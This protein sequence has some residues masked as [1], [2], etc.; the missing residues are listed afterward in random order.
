MRLKGIV[1]V[2]L[3]AFV[4]ASLVYLLV[5]E[6]RK[7]SAPGAAPE[8]A[9]GAPP[10]EAVM[11][12]PPAASE[13]PGPADGTRQTAPSR[14]IVYYFH[15]TVRCATCQNIEDYSREA[16][17]SGF[18]DA[19]TAGRLEWRSVDVDEAESQ[20]FVQDYKL[21]TRSLVVV[22][23]RDAKQ[24]AWKNLFA[25]WDLVGDKPAFTSYV[26]DEVRAWLENTL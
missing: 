13:A 18:P 3:L 10:P 21:A 23:T 25:I 17:L 11:G 1:K 20:H 4:C 2:V 19:V 7:R 14:I 15:G 24:T 16:I 8:A 5:T 22:Q 26:Q 9:M 12:A 6:A